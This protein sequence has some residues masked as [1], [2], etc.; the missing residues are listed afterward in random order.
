[1]WN[2]FL[3]FLSWVYILLS[4]FEPT[5]RFDKSLEIKEFYIMLGIETFIIILQTLDFLMEII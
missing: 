3:L 5:N 1:M 4:F 2:D